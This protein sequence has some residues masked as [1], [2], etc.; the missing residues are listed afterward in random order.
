M[1]WNLLQTLRETRAAYSAMLGPSFGTKFAR[2]LAV[3]MCG[4]V[5]MLAAFCGTIVALVVG[6]IVN[7]SE[8]K[9]YLGAFIWFLF[10][11][12]GIVVSQT[13]FLYLRNLGRPVVKRMLSLDL[14]LTPDYA[15]R[16]VFHRLKMATWI[17]LHPGLKV[18]MELPIAK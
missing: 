10:T 12:L 6:F 16:L 1:R 3:V 4:Y 18:E 2:G 13:A 17:D 15:R 11:S 9:S 14:S 8:A 5:I 7:P